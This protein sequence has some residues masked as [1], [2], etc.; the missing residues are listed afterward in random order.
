MK[1]LLTLFLFISSLAQ[2]QYI[3]VPKKAIVKVLSEAKI[4]FKDTTT[5]KVNWMQFT[6]SGKVVTLYLQ[7]D[8]V[9]YFSTFAPLAEINKTIEAYNSAFERQG[10]FKWV[11]Y[12]K[13]GNDLIVE[14]KKYSEGFLTVI[15]K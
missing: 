4:Q 9:Q 11:D 10:K 7:K 1:K 15:S 12:S 6:E 3:G 13:P 2:A 8:S 14:I 5:N